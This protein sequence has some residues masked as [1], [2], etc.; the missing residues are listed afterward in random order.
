ME[1]VIREQEPRERS[2]KPSLTYHLS[3]LEKPSKTIKERS[4]EHWEAA[5]GSQKV[6]AWSHFH[7]HQIMHHGGEKP[8]FVMRVVEFHHTPL[9]RQTAEAVRIMKRGEAGAVLNSKCEYN[10]CY[11]SRLRMVEEDTAKELELAKAFLH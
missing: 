6:K 5:R 2:G 3:M 8:N 4:K 7:K 11:I 10:H 9:S 1:L